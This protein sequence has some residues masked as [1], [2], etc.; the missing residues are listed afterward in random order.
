MTQRWLPFLFLGVLAAGRASAQDAW[1]QADRETRRLAPSSFTALP[2]KV[3]SAIEDRRCLVP[4]SFAEA[5]P[6]NVVRGSFAHRGQTD[7]AVLCSR[8]HASTILVVWGG[9]GACPDEMEVREDRAFLTK[10]ASGSIRFARRLGL[11]SREFILKMHELYGGE[12]PPPLDHQG[13][14][15]GFLGRGSTIRYCDSGKW[16]ELTGQQE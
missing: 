8:A 9:P 10:D 12:A 14:E 5:T 4:Q 15:D 6:H 11:A 16:L 3:L 13:I 7:W 1:T 2:P